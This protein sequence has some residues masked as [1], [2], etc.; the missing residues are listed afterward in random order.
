MTVSER[1]ANRFIGSSQE[2]PVRIAAVYPEVAGCAIVKT[3][4]RH[5]V[6][7][8]LGWNAVA[9]PAECA[10]AGMALQAYGEHHGAPQQPGVCRSVRRMAG[11]AAIHSHGRVLEEKGPAVLSVAFE[12][13][14]LVRRG[15]FYHPRPRSHSPGRRGRAVRIV[16]ICALD[17]AFIH[18][19]LEG[20]VEL[21]AHG[22]MAVVT[23]I[24]LCF[25]EQELG[26]C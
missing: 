4:I 7:W 10:G 17:N 26:R 1:R 11:L 20:H 12:A 16:A 25:G 5:V 23:E 13:G 8:R 18:S 21:R 24:R 22:S 15:V 3:G 6:R 9:L 19:M 2:Q 14:L